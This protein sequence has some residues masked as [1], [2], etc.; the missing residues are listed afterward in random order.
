VD[1]TPLLDFLSIH[2]TGGVLIACQHYCTR[3]DSIKVVLR[4][5]R[6]ELDFIHRSS[7]RLF[8]S[9]Y[10]EQFNSAD[11]K[12]KKSSRIIKAH[13]ENGR[14]LPKRIREQLYADEI[15]GN[16]LNLPKRRILVP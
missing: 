4:R 2:L 13:L 15:F 5:R 11:G 9:L 7:R 10:R 16:I 1:I 3:K 8:S 12:A 14:R 6:T